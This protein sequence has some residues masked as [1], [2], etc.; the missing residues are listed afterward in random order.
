MSVQC[1]DKQTFDAIL[2]GRYH[3]FRLGDQ[4]ES[5]EGCY[6]TVK[7]DDRASK[8]RPST[9]ESAKSRVT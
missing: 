8:S 5:T 6:K 4:H 9:Q 7:A 1:A 3:T 2:S